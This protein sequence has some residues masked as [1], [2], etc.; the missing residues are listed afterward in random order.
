[1]FIKQDRGKPR[2]FFHNIRY[3]ANGSGRSAT[4]LKQRFR[5]LKKLK[6]NRCRILD[7]SKVFFDYADSIVVFLILIWNHISLCQFVHCLNFGV[8][9]TSKMSIEYVF[10][11][12]FHLV[13]NEEPTGKRAN[14]TDSLNV[15]CTIFLR[16]ENKRCDAS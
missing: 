12:Y 7:F 15:H 6:S 16:Q 3:G 5:F 9:R 1:M 14:S 4:A 11:A 13:L 10:T 8:L 2:D